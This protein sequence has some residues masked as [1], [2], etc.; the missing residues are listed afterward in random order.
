MSYSALKFVHLAAVAASFA[1]FF[2]RGVWMMR[3]SALLERRWVRIVPHVNDTAL[4]ASGVALAVLLRISPAS[5]PWLA[6][7]LVALLVYIGLGMI[8]LRPRR[9]KRVRIAS[10]AAALVVFGYIAAVAV[11]RS[12][13]L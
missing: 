7:K 4:L 6:A 11:T 8:A 3:G 5:S 9:T 1:L 10:W 12:A 13:S 2:V